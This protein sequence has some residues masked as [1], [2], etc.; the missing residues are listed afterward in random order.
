M[1]KLETDADT[2]LRECNELTNA[3]YGLERQIDEANVENEA[4]SANF[5][6]ELSDD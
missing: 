4:R 1:L 5:E 6:H 2:I 3:K